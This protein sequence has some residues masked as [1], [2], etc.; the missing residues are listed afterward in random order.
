MPHPRSSAPPGAS[1]TFTDATPCRWTVHEEA[2]R[3]EDWTTSDLEHHRDGYGVGWLVFRSADRVA[4]L[5]LYRARWDLLTD[6]EL[7]GLCRRA[8]PVER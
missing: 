2:F 1:R 4:L 3:R 7:E 8:R 6:A 5:R